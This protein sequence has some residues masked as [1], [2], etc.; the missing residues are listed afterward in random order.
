MRTARD[1]SHL[2]LADASGSVATAELVGR[3]DG[4]RVALHRPSGGG[5]VF[6]QP[7]LVSPPAAPRP[8]TRYVQRRL[9]QILLWPTPQVGHKRL[10]A[11]PVDEDGAA[12]PD[13]AVVSLCGGDGIAERRRTEG[14]TTLQL[15]KLK[16]PARPV[17]GVPAG[18]TGPKPKAATGRISTSRRPVAPR[19]R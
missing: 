19:R 9:A 6:A 14:A 7:T 10:A 12:L 18:T 2:A 5:T 17:R 16:I 15:V 1:T 8:I 11:R 13:A 4:S 3:V